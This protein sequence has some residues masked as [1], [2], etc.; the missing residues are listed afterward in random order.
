MR[1]R[2]KEYEDSGAP[3]HKRKR[4]D[5]SEE[6]CEEPASKKATRSPM[7]P[8]A[9]TNMLHVQRQLQT[10][11]M[12]S[13]AKKKRQKSASQKMPKMTISRRKVEIESESETEEDSEME[14]DSEA[15]TENDEELKRILTKSISKSLA[16]QD[17]QLRDAL[18][19][20]IGIAIRKAEDNFMKRSF[21]ESDCEIDL[22]SDISWKVGLL[23][24]DINKYE[25]LL[26][27][28]FDTVEQQVPTIIKI[29][30]SNMEFL[31]K[32]S[33][34]EKL[35][36]LNNLERDTE[37]YYEVKHG[38]R[39]LID[40]HTN[41][42]LPHEVI[43][44]CHEEEKVIRKK[45]RGNIPMKYK[46]LSSKMRDN[47]KKV[48]YEKYMRLEETLT[49]DQEYAKLKEYIEWGLSMPSEFKFIQAQSDDKTSLLVR[50]RESL[51]KNLYGMNRVKE[52]IIHFVNNRLTNR[53]NTDNVLVLIGEPGVGKTSIAR[54]IGETLN[55]PWGQISFGGVDDSSYINGHSYTY[56]GAIPGMIIQIIKRLACMD[57]LIFF[58]EIDK[59]GTTAKGS[60][61][62][63]S[64][65]HV[66]DSTQN[67]DFSDKYLGDIRVDLS[68]YWWVVA[69]NGFPSDSALRDRMKYAIHVD[70]YT[71]SE[72]VE[73]AKRH[74]F[75]DA[76][77]NL[78]ISLDE[79]IIDDEA[80]VHLI[81]KSKIKEAGVRQLKSN[82]KQIVSRMNMLLNNNSD[83]MR[84][85][86][87]GK[88][89][90]LSPITINKVLIDE[91]F[92]EY[93]DKSEVPLEHLYI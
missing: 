89:L 69:G 41:I 7:T 28:I 72:K 31:E 66:L 20:S 90:T 33:A 10:M 56:E 38:L 60:E 68:H 75:P 6:T 51:D 40:T 76:F 32:C 27:K 48:L 15:E 11:L 21:H 81:N 49:T 52:E 84:L 82:V 86:Y 8:L 91:L 2:S 63:S 70:G 25:P 16:N 22:E 29:L 46:I 62:A 42:N 74:L 13:E 37:V 47:N 19:S 24:E 30:K 26:Q 80:I 44:R 34:I 83:D 18:E 58:D 36:I 39:K 61:V 65:L 35:K 79:V 50:L 9:R 17:D 23:E 73:I 59:I 3:N 77:R 5:E 88:N 93:I 45:I 78:M 64:L 71:S 14:E 54:A 57:G 43:E 53:E 92:C 87:T 55:I 12:K 85:S 67:K 1:T 4:S